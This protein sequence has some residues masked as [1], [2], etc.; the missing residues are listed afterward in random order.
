[1]RD[2]RGWSSN[3]ESLSQE[4]GRRGRRWPAL[5]PGAWAERLGAGV[6]AGLLLFLCSG[7]A[8]AQEST[9][10]PAAPSETLT[11]KRA[12]ELA[13]RNS[14]DLRAARLQQEVAEKSV[15]VANAEFRPN[16]Y[17][18]SGAGYTN[19][20]PETPVGRAPSIFNMSYTQQIFNP[21]L[22]GHVRELEER[23]GAQGL[24]ADEVR[25][26]VI[27]RAVSEYLELAKT[28]HSLAL[29]R[30]G[31]KSAERIL[32]VTQ[33]RFTEGLELSLEVTRAR[34]EVAKMARRILELEGREDSLATSLRELTGLPQD[35]P[36]EVSA[37]ELPA[38]AEQQGADLMG[39]AMAN[40]TDL[41][42]AESE[43]RGR[44]LRL[45]G[46]AGGRWP[47][48]GLVG[49]YSV[50]DRFNNY[51]EFFNKFQR[52]NVNVGVQIEIPIFS[53][54]TNASI[55]LARSNLKAAEI[56]VQAQRAELGADVKRQTHRTRE[57]EAAKEVARL[58]LQLA[59][60]QL[61]MLQTQFQEGR[62]SLRDVEKARLQESDRWMEFL[63][64]EFARQQAQ[65]ELL[66]TTGQLARVFQ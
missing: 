17:A 44:E 7:G 1:M 16:L 52:H 57:L 24:R 20:I 9:A 22:K 33:E 56:K 19:G 25:D 47:T 21:P 41:K 5:T 58:E 51:D 48:L 8:R 2:R 40:N 49:T 64:A 63:E 6:C 28:R 34:L 62:T 50:L 35:A 18:G 60:Q 31:Q 26:L 66:K 61:A 36:L 65:L 23:A 11:V 13:L 4:R 12:V 39:L 46:E 55:A 27:V 37:E 14:R 10:L 29:L 38:A 43:R 53:A 3:R 15:R 42:Q 30:A 32:E 45:K 54:R 59:Q